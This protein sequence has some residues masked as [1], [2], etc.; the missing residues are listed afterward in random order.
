MTRRRCTETIDDCEKGLHVTIERGYAAADDTDWH[1]TIL[2]NAV[3]YRVRYKSSRFGKEC[4]TP[5]WTTFF[6]GVP[7]YQ[8]YEPVPSWLQPLVDKVSADLGVPFNALLLRLYFDGDDEIAWHTDG[9]TFLGKTPVIASLSFGATAT[10]QM[11]RMNNVWPSV[12]GSG[13][14]SDGIDHGTPVRDFVVKDGDMLIMRHVTQQH[15]HHRVPKQKGRRPRL[16]INFRRIIPGRPDAER[17]QKTYYKY[18]VHGDETQPRSYS[19][20]EIMAKR[21]GMMNFI[22]PVVKGNSKENAAAKTKKQSLASTKEKEPVNGQSKKGGSSSKEHD[23]DGLDSD[24]AA[25]L[26]S[27]RTVDKQTFL[28]LPLEMRRELINDWRWCRSMTIKRQRT[29]S[30][31]T[32]TKNK[33]SRVNTLDKFFQKKEKSND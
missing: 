15:W 8:P 4:E 12:D 33:R 31:A 29:A 1:Q 10:F 16:N 25:Y 17:G 23:D 18:M 30:M 28:A 21:G 11:R 6:G 7:D 32:G 14:G 22:S 27:E 2:D 19:F 3:W 20:Q 24:C 5:C 26:E 13:G 9:R